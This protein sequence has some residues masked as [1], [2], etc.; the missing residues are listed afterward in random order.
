VNTTGVGLIRVA[1]G[2]GGHLGFFFQG[3][4]V[5]IFDCITPAAQLDQVSKQEFEPLL[6]SFAF[7]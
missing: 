7:T 6:R 1:D 4:D 2:Q 3:P 5:Y